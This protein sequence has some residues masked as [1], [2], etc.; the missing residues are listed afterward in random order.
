MRAKFIS[1][2]YHQGHK[3]LEYDYRGRRYD[4]LADWNAEPLAWQHRSNQDLIDRQIEIL[5]RSEKNK[6]T[7]PAEVGYNA[8]MK[9]F[10]SGVWEDAPAESKETS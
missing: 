9:Y 8:I 2:Y 10:E 3:F 4:V 1:A 6:N 7:E 5:A